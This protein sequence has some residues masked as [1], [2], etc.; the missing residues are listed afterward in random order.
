[1]TFF[2]IHSILLCSKK[3]NK[4]V[5]GKMSQ[6]IVKKECPICK[7][8][9]ETAGTQEPE[10]IVLEPCPNCKKLSLNLRKEKIKEGE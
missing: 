2:G 1:M 4:K 9:W 5:G 10:M 8:T 6:Q 7:K 3:K